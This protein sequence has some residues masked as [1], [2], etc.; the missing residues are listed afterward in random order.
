MSTTTVKSVW[1]GERT[2]DLEELRNSHGSAPVVWNEMAK[3]YLGLKDFEYLRHGDEIWPIYK[4]ADMPAHHRVVLMMTY[5]YAI[6]MKANY[7]QAATDIRAFL[8]DSPLL[9]EYA[10]HWPRIAQLFASEPECP[11]IGFHMTSVSDDPFQGKY[12]EEI[13]DY[14][15]PDWE[16]YWDAYAEA[17]KWPTPN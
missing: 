5:D 3:R 6:V 15:A 8:A 9:Q 2:E 4:R 1:P 7:A 16:Q 14:D 17:S 11:A 10:N 13:D 12:N